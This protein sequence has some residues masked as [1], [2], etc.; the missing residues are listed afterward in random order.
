MRLVRDLKFDSSAKNSRI[1]D[2]RRKYFLRVPCISLL[3]LAFVR[4]YQLD[5]PESARYAPGKSWQE[6]AGA[7]SYPRSFECRAS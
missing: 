5:E 2:G 1:Q 3:A 7:Q 6:T 4:I